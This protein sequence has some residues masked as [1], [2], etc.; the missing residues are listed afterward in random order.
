MKLAAIFRLQKT[1]KILEQ[2]LRSQNFKSVTMATVA[3]GYTP[4]PNQL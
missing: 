3:A 4:K 2:T 1:L